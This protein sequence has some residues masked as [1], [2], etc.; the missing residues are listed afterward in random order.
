M[1]IPSQWHFPVQIIQIIISL[2]NGQINKTGTL[3]VRREKKLGNSFACEKA[4]SIRMGSA[5]SVWVSIL[6]HYLFNI[7][8]IDRHDRLLTNSLQI[9]LH[10]ASVTPG[11]R[12]KARQYSEP[13]IQNSSTFKK[14]PVKEV[15]P[16]VYYKRSWITLITL[17][18]TNQH[19]LI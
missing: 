18:L 1:F 14:Q 12:A 9:N 13:L 7:S 11:C 5:W 8:L 10:S 19:P 4:V 3:N 2:R 15:W 16:V 17:I 6:L